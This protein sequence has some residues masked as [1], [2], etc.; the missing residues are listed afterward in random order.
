MKEGILSIEK[1]FGDL[2]DPRE[3]PAIHDLTEMLL[4]ALCAIL[5][6]AD[7]WV[8]IQLWVSGGFAAHGFLSRWSATC[9]HLF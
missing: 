3:R 1:A 6:G 2:A 4:V 8:G 9:V 5:C 7:S